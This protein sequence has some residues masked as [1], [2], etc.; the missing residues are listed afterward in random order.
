MFFFVFFFMI[1]ALFLLEVVRTRQEVKVSCYWFSYCRIDSECHGFMSQTGL[2][3]S[4]ISAFGSSVT[5]KIIIITEE[6]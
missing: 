1:F 2:F 3:H 6:F 5:V 4:W